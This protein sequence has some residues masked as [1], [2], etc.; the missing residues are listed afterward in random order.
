MS[1][2]AAA[3]GRDM[4]WP[5]VAHRYLETFE[6][7]SAD[8][9][10][11][12][13]AAFQTRT[14]A[15]RPADLPEINL[16]HL[17]TMTDSTGILQ[18]AAYN[19]PRY[20]DGYCLDDNARA[21]LLTTI[22]EDEGTEDLRA[23]RA[24][25]SRYL[26]FVNHAFNVDTGRF[27]NF[28][29]YARQWSENQG[30]EDSQGRALWALGSVVGRSVDP[31]KQNLGSRLFH[32]GLPVVTAFSSPRAWAFTLLG[33]NEYLRAFKGDTNVQTV[34]AQLAEK[35][36]GLFQ[37]THGKDWPWFEDGLTYSNARLSQA[38]LISG[39]RMHNEE[40]KEAGLKSLE[41]LVSLDFSEEGYFSPVGS[42]GFHE[43]GKTRAMFDQQPVEA[44]AMVSACMEA[45]RS[46]GE[47]RWVE[48][49]RRTF[50]WFLGQNQIQQWLYDATTG[51][52]RDGLHA[53][54]VNENQGAESTLSFLLAL[55]D[56]RSA[57]RLDAEK[58][59]QREIPK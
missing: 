58:S 20:D 27:R 16:G 56:M 28:M 47:E 5:A 1:R 57:D 9:A 36:L 13:R 26:A 3:Y 25:S 42:N 50:G 4:K 35:L 54:R 46:T 29:S 18:H 24:L 10:A 22:I 39:A 23:V 8:H 12:R 30:S 37:R 34:R 11:R 32:A 53:D 51:G 59:I 48:T 7:A 19:V 15:A 17:D 40:M 44:C 14:L 41:W 31:G 52:C 33:I 55:C 43:R 38:L 21:L 45:H 6:R 49:A 2:R